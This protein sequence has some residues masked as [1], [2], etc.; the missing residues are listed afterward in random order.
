MKKNL[1]LSALAISAAFSA[2]AGVDPVQYEEAVDGLRCTNKWLV[3][4]ALDNEEFKKLVF[5]EDYD[6]C[7]TA[8][9]L[10]DKVYVGYSHKIEVNGEL[11]SGTAFLVEHDLNTGEYLRTIQCTLNGEII[12]G[13]L[14][15]NQVGTDD[16]GHL[17]FAGFRSNI[18]NGTVPVYV[19]DDLATGAC[20]VAFEVS[21]PEDEAEAAGRVDYFDLVGDVT[22]K[23]G[24]TVFMSASCENT[25]KPYVYGWRRDQG[26]DKFEPHMADG[27]YVA[28][29]VE[30][31][32]PAGQLLFNYGSMVYISRDEEFSGAMYYVDGF[33]TY[34]T[35]Y[36]TEGG[37]IES[38][39]SA[40]DQQPLDAQC[41]GVVEFSLGDD[42]YIAYPISQYNKGEGWQFRVC[43]LGPDMAFEGMQ[44]LWDLPKGG[45]G[46]ISDGGMR[47]HDL[48]VQKHVDAN[49][50]EA[51]YLFN[52]KCN[53]GMGVYEIA[54]PEYN[55]GIKGVEVA[56]SNAPVEYFNLNGIRM[57]EN[58]LPAGLYITRQ[59]DKVSKLIVK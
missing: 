56:D 33:T 43:K 32:F 38:F 5:S 16:F 31:T 53:G 21:L 1:L 11:N 19:V 2:S 23:E 36:N 45:M 8:T 28:Q 54:Q 57:N 50:N 20:S 6:R 30:E 44:T 55:S 17:W 51:V 27:G 29:A 3:S 25:D 12:E 9:V 7:R 4:K 59:G 18:A 58:N 37:M 10:G 39:A 34:P 26:S 47:I 41:N 22:G 35:L 13:L 14:C 52:Y 40:P 46:T 49:G 15:A 24:P 42:F 48:K